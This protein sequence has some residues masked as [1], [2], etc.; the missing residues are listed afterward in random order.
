MNPQELSIPQIL[1]IGKLSQ[2]LYNVNNQKNTLFGGSAIDPRR[3]VTIYQVWKPL[4]IRFSAN[5]SDPTL[6][7]VAEYLLELS[8]PSAKTIISNLSGSLPVITGPSNQSGL[9]GF[10]ATF[11]VSVAGTGPFTFQWYRGGVL[12]PGATSS[13]LPITNAQL[14][15]NGAQFFV[16]VTNAVGTQ[17]SG[18]AL[19]TVTASII[20]R[21]YAGGTDYSTL[22]AAGTDTVA[23]SGTFAITDEQPLVV[24]FPAGQVDFIVVQYPVSQSVK[25]HYANPAGGFDQAA[26]PGLALTVNTFGGNN[27]IFSQNGAPFGINNATGLITFS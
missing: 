22:L 2:V 24:P 21:W 14:T 1:Q 18:T 11:S 13:T 8:D 6:R 10:T 5:P 23:Y 19:L 15:D 9:S 16:T 27:Y 4:S 20:G 3:P 26:I 7:Q 12:V 17:V 25:T